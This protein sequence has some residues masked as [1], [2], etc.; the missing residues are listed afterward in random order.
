MR[1]AL[2]F[3]VALAVAS[4]VPADGDMLVICSGGGVRLVLQ[5]AGST[6][7]PE[8]TPCDSKACHALTSRRLLVRG[9]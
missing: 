2:S 9:S 8:R 3:A 4:P 5:P 6:P 1:L 7:V